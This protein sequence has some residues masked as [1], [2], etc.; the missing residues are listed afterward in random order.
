MTTPIVGTGMVTVLI[1]DD[2]AGLRTVCARCLRLAEMEAF[3]AE[4]G[5]SALLLVGAIHPLVVVVDLHMPGLDGGY[6]CRHLATRTGPRPAIV[7]TS[8]GEID[9]L[10]LDFDVFLPKPFRCGDLIAAVH[11]ALGMR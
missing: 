7:V 3:T 1:V 4:D 5:A 10:E 11:R 2:E 6:V 9:D 8:G